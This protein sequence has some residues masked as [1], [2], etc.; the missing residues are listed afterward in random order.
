MKKKALLYIVV[1]SVLWGTSGLFIHVLTP[2]GFSALQLTAIRGTVSSICLHG[3]ALIRDRSLYR[4]RWKELMIFLCSG[5]C[6][7]GTAACYYS[8]VIASSVSTA[9]ILMYTAPVYVMAFSVAFLG[10]RFKFPKLV[11]VVF[12]IAGC[13]LVS[14]IVGGM[15]FSLIGILLGVASGIIYSGYDIIF[16]LRLR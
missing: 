3:Y 1:A 5:L 2:L 14:G 9:V 16:S 7:Y 12:M 11:A 4:I 15:K 6:I 8:S 13:A 10:E